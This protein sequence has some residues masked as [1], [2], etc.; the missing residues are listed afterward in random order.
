MKLAQ[1]KQVRTLKECIRTK[2]SKYYYRGGG[3]HV[4]CG[5]CEVIVDGNYSSVVNNSDS[6][7]LDS[8]R[9]SMK[10]ALKIINDCKRDF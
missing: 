9:I 2:Y 5:N 7:K 6:E 10:A 4:N 8:K 3:I 1:F